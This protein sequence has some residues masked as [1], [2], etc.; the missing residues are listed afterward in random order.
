MSTS[1]RTRAA[2]LALVGAAL[3]TS[4]PA[5]T[6]P[7]SAP[8]GL[9]VGVGVGFWRGTAGSVGL[10]S[11]G[12]MSAESQLDVGYRFG[13]MFGVELGFRFFDAENSQQ[14]HWH[15]RSYSVA[16]AATTRFCL[17]PHVHVIGHLGLELQVAP[18]DMHTQGYQLSQTALAFAVHPRA[19]LELALPIEDVLEVRLRALA[20]YAFRTDLA[21]DALRSGD[22]GVAPLNA[23]STN[24]SGVSFALTA[25]VGF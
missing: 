17:F 16:L 9:E 13:E 18:L 25:G 11:E 23:G 24:L 22:P 19:G 14:N 2:V 1:A 10:I 5:A 7:P 8:I 15:I 20:G 12:T 3:L 6:E 21:Y 4:S